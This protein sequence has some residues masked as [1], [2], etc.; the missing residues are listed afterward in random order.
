MSKK[1]GRV[2]PASKG[3]THRERGD[4][5]LRG[6]GE[7][8]AGSGRQGA[9]T[10]RRVRH[11]PTPSDPP[12]LRVLLAEADR[13]GQTVTAMAAELGVSPGY[14]F[15]LRNGLRQTE[16]IGQEF[17]VACARY[18]RIPVVLVK[19]W[20]GR[21]RLTDFG[22]PS[23]ATNAQ[24]DRDLAELAKDPAYAGL[25]PEEFGHISDAMKDLVWNLY[26]EATGRQPPAWVTMPRMLDYL[27]RAALAMEEHEAELRHLDALF[28]GAQPKESDSHA[29]VAH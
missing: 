13:R 20:A 21:I 17:A 11:Q 25:V 10:G 8:H 18:L 28:A 2:Q 22:W 19:L 9:G 24:R 29:E 14:V 12:L 7:R 15:Q 1:S 6:A 26:C 16:F 27:Q 4:A 5:A 3:T 23:Q